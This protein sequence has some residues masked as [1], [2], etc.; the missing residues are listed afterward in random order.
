MFDD[1]VNAPLRLYGRAFYKVA[2]FPTRNIS[3]PIYLI[4]GTKD[5]LVDINA[6]LHEL[7]PYAVAIPVEN[8]EHLDLI[9]GED[10]GKVVVPHVLQTLDKYFD[11]QHD[12]SDEYENLEALKLE[13][14]SSNSSTLS[15]SRAS[16]MAPVLSG[17]SSYPSLGPSSLSQMVGQMVGT[18]EDKAQKS[19]SDANAAFDADERVLSDAD[20][21]DASSRYETASSDSSGSTGTIKDT[22][23]VVPPS[24]TSPPISSSSKIA[25]RHRNSSI[26]SSSIPRT[27]SPDSPKLLHRTAVLN[28]L[29]GEGSGTGI[30]LGAAEAVTGVVVPG[31]NGRTVVKERKRRTSLTQASPEPIEQP[32]YDEN[33]EPSTKTG[34]KQVSFGKKIELTGEKIKRSILGP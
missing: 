13:N 29:Q 14:T 34:Q 18:E 22:V 27:A 23:T 30:V 15:F 6:M 31:G 8:H 3:S 32:D 2:Q 26:R 20:D 4:Y 25:G 11:V 9:W 24:P 5:S 7:P 1:D 28:L 12:S 19:L 10:V 16:S 17:L 21:N 33:E